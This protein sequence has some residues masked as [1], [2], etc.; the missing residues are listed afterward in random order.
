VTFR[1]CLLKERKGRDI[2]TKCGRTKGV[3]IDQCTVWHTDVDCPGCLQLM[4]VT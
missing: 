1:K 2:T 4:V 3:T